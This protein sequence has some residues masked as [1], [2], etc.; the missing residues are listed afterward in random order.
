MRRS[1]TRFDHYFLEPLPQ[2]ISPIV[3]CYDF[4]MC[5]LPILPFFYFPFVF[6]VLSVHYYA[7]KLFNIPYKFKFSDPYFFVPILIEV[8]I[9]FWIPGPL[10][11]LSNHQIIIFLFKGFTSGRSI[12]YYIIAGSPYSRNKFLATLIW[13][14]YAG[15]N[16]KVL[17][18][19][20][21][22]ICGRNCPFLFDCYIEVSAAILTYLFVNYFFRNDQLMLNL[23]G[24]AYFLT[25]VFLYL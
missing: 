4:A 16:R 3:A 13:G 21:A 24:A 14:Y 8:Y 9:L 17:T 23:V 5:G 10:N 15:F 2:L 6:F 18:Y 11:F 1:L 22:Y 7:L 12:C 19:I 25:C 20:I